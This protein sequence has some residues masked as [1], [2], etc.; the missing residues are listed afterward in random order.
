MKKILIANR[1]EIALRIIH[2][3]KQMGIETVAVYSDADS[4]MPFVKEA[5]YSFRIGESPVNKSYLNMDQ[6]IEIAIRE[7]VD[8]I[9]PGYGLLSENSEFARKVVDNG[10]IF[11]GPSPD[12][13]E[14]MGDKIK[15][16]TTMHEA[17]V[18]IVPGSIRGIKSLEE[19]Q[20][21]ANQ[22]GYPIMLKASG[23]GGG[24]GMVRCENEQALN[25]HY[26]STKARSKAYFGS[27]EVFIEK[28]IDNAR[29]IEVQIFGDQY[30]N[31]VHLYE[32]NCSVQR[33]NQKVIEEAQ[34]PNI[35]SETRKKMYTAAIDAA[36]AV[37][38]K[39]AGTVEFIVDENE[40]FYFLEMNT[41]LQVEHPVTELLTTLD[42]VKWQILV[43]RGE[44]LPLSQNEIEKSGHAIELRIYAEDPKTFFPS[45]GMIT[46]LSWGNI[47]GVRIDAGYHS[48]LQVTPFYD[49]MIAK[50]VIFASNR[51]DCIQKA[52]EFLDQTIIEGIKTN[53]PFLK[54]VLQSTNFQNGD[55]TTNL[56]NEMK[57]NN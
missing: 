8:G 37:G 23:G 43:A 39:N 41:R 44:K 45:P 28:C 35:S 46:Q 9:H 52:Q 26:E 32:R 15:A 31:I 2:T 27:D 25:Q 12:T 56:V 38:Y 3:C 17:G 10:I 54:N 29:H 53:I 6:L 4:C 19:A 5:D 50:C 20:D 11:I 13:I 40:H 51:T 1:G 48:G 47:E 34:S 49:P 16:R 42:L 30:G 14:S 33:R 18:P 21:L 24:I 22:I 57:V 7:K 55:Y 36:K